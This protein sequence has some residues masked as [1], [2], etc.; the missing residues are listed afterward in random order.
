MQAFFLR[1]MEN[2]FF[3]FIFS[4]LVSSLFFSSLISVFPSDPYFFCLRPYLQLVSKHHSLCSWNLCKTVLFPLTTICFVSTEANWFSVSCVPC[5][6]GYLITAVITAHSK[7]CFVRLCPEPP[8][9]EE[10]MASYL[11]TII[12]LPKFPVLYQLNSIFC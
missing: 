5:L 6:P 12:S 4:L 10:K 11:Q 1:Q 8:F 3:N 7:L 2:I 9:P